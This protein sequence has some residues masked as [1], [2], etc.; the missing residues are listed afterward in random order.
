MEK[1]PDK[2]A[3]LRL[4]A[5]NKGIVMK[6]CNIYCDNNADR[7]D[8]AQ[9]IIY[10]LWKGHGTYNPAMKY[11]T[12]MYRVALNVAISF[13][14]AAVAYRKKLMLA[15]KEPGISG[16]VAADAT[17]EDNFHLLQLHIAA[18]GELDK[19]L[20]MLHFEGNS[21]KEIAEVIG[22]TETNVASRL[23][24]IKERLKRDITTSKKS[25]DGR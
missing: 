23:S 17:N 12:W 10:T 14:R 1:Q 11:T 15:E 24:R 4:L 8:L 3:F 13:N 16:S 5:D 18:L 2:E 6:I 20:V 7:E 19:A 9:E 25:N 21:Y 22:I